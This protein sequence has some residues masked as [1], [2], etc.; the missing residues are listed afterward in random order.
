MVN[1]LASLAMS[2]SVLKALLGK[3]DT[4]R[5]SPSILY[6]F[7][8]QLANILEKVAFWPQPNPLN[9]SRRSYQGLQDRKFRREDRRSASRGLLSDDKR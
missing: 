4:K 6:L 2:K 5:H 7:D 3:L 1:G 9:S 8:I